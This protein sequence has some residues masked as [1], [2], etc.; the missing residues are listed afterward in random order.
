MRPISILRLAVAAATS[1]MLSGAVLA[2]TEAAEDSVAEDTIE[3]IFVTGSRIP[4]DS[5][6]VST[7]LVSVDNEAIADTGLGSLAEILIDEM[8]AL[9]E[10]QS[11]MNSQSQIGNTGVTSVTFVI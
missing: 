10:G 8:P 4:R 2:Q 11:H 1:M 5:F 3:E 7:P 6:N 9:Y